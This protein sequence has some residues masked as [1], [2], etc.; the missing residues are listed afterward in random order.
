MIIRTMPNNAAAADSS[1]TTTGLP[2]SCAR[3]SPNPNSAATKRM[4]MMSPFTKGSTKELGIIER[5]NSVRPTP[6]ATLA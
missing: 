3:L 2:R 1:K 5:K 6:L 4:G